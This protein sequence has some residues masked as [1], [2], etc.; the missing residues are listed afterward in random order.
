[1]KKLAGLNHVVVKQI[2]AFKNN[3]FTGALNTRGLDSSILP[4]FEGL[5][6]LGQVLAQAER[7]QADIAAQ[8]KHYSG[9]LH[10]SMDEL[11]GT[12]DQQNT[13]SAQAGAT[14]EGCPARRMSRWRARTLAGSSL[15]IQSIVQ[16]IQQI[17]G[18][19]NLLALNAAI[20]AAR[21]GDLGRGF[22]VV[23]D[24]VR[25]LAEITRRMRRNRRGYR[26]VVQRNPARGPAD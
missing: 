22:A 13:V 3:D 17:A 15:R 20:E 7:Q 4:V 5:S 1:V 19:T 25:K 26:P 14:V 24:E 10:A 21:A 11:V 23:A 8:I 6:D 18:Q 9:E 12:I 2:A 16:V